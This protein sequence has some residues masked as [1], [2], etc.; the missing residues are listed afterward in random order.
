ME[1]TAA[2]RLPGPLVRFHERYPE[3]NVELTT[4]DPQ[5]LM[6]RVI[7]GELD[8]ALVAEPVVDSRL[9]TLKAAIAGEE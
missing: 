5:S 4:S 7:A 3:V 1:S 9:E 8:A 2:A 6:A